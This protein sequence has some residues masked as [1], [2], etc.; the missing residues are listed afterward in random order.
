MIRASKSSA[1]NVGA[2]YMLSLQGSSYFKY[3]HRY[4]T[5]MPLY[6]PRLSPTMEEGQISEW[7][8]SVGEEI[9]SGHVIA[10]IETDKAVLDYTSSGEEGFVARILVE[11]GERVKTGHP[12]AL[13]VEEL[14]EIN[15]SDVKNWTNSE[16][17]AKKS[18]SDSKIETGG[19]IASTPTKISDDRIKISPL[20]LSTCKKEGIPIN[21]LTGTGGDVNRIIL[22]DVLDYKDTAKSQESKTVEKASKQLDR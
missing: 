4:I 18:P 13:L 1:F 11:P 9:E 21:K 20:A 17:H 12:I 8:K 10:A 15:A 5:I 2:R 3:V 19:D 14:D 16:D 7:K 22:Q 6:M